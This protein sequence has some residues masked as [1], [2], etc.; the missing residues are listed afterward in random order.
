LNL[1]TGQGRSVR[2]VIDAVERVSGHKVPQ[3]EA[4]P[5]AGDPPELVADAS[6]A[7]QQ[8]DWHPRSSDL[9]TIIK[10]ALAWHQR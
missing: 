7:A 8:L 2:E 3:R 1:G 6:L 10:T 5:R 4:A 9:E